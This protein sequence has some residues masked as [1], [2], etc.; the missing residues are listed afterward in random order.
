MAEENKKININS[1]FD[2]VE[3]VDMVAG[4]ALRQVNLNANA[5]QANKTLI[6]SL[7]VTIEAM[8]TEIRDI[9]NYIVIE[10]KLERD[11]EKISS[12]LDN[13]VIAS[14]NRLLVA[15]FIK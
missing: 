2:R 8:R 7:S 15:P 5:I 12:A 6:N 13:I 14:S 9:A 10:N 4:N 11:K 1:F 3:E